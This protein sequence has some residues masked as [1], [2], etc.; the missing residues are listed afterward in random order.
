M[1]LMLF[2]SSALPIESRAEF[3][4]GRRCYEAGEF[5]AAASHLQKAVK[6]DPSDAASYFWLGKSHEMLADI[7]GPVLGSRASSKARL[8]LVKALE[9]APAN[10]E[11]RRELFDF[12]LA[13]DRTPGALHQ[14]ERV[15]QMTPQSDPDYPFM[16]MQLENERMARSSRES[17]IAAAFTL[18]EE[19]LSRT[20]LRSGPAAHN[21]P[22]ILL[23]AQSAR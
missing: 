7:N 6:A 14:A 17:R 19:P 18:L 16:S 13:S 23:L 3:E 11:Y 10:R 5:K 4:T 22:G 20:G 8:Y 15:I 9:L 12:L 1:L 21:N 2:A